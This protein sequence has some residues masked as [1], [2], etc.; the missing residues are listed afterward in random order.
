MCEKSSTFA[1]GFRK[2]IY[3]LAKKIEYK[4]CKRALI[5]IY[6][7]FCSYSRLLEIW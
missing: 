4:R 5:K 6:K 7:G 2:Y 1:A 3:K